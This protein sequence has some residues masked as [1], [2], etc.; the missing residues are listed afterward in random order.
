MIQKIKHFEKFI[1][2]E[3]LFLAVLVQLCFAVRNSYSVDF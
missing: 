1:S 3:I 2:F